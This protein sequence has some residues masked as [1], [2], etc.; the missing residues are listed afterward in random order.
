MR[1]RFEEIEC[2]GHRV[3]KLGLNPND[4]A[5]KAGAWAAALTN[6]DAKGAFSNRRR[7]GIEPE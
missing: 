7:D 4:P 3:G 5:G 2:P 6:A 1:V